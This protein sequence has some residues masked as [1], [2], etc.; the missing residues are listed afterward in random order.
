MIRYRKI[1]PTCISEIFGSIAH[2]II[3]DGYYIPTRQTILLCTENFTKED[4]EKLVNVLTSFGIKSSVTHHSKKKSTYRIRIS[5]TSIETVR[6]LVLPYF[7][8]EF[9]YKLGLL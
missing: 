3:E 1:V 9:M 7:H 2:W 6:N 4:C 8:K 5:K